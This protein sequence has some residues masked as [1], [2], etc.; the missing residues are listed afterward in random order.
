MENY[1]KHLTTLTEAVNILRDALRNFIVERIPK[2]KECEFLDKIEG[3]LDSNKHG[4]KTL[5]GIVTNCRQGQTKIENVIDI[6]YLNLVCHH[7]SNRYRFLRQSTY[8]KVR[9][10]R[11]CV[12]HPEFEDL[13]EQ[14]FKKY[15]TTIHTLLEN[16][17][18]FE[19]AKIIQS[20]RDKPFEQSHYNEAKTRR[21]REKTINRL[22]KISSTS[23]AE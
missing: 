3:N 2:G 4:D 21:N 1:R 15:M 19:E 20:L 14:K 11:N 16:I 23:R 10:I 9:D 6:P 7:V 17:G 22:T 12:C 18:Y 13:S 8:Y 5:K